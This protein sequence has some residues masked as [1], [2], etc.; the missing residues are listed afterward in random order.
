M[1]LRPIGSADASLLRGIY[2]DAVESQAPALYSDQQ[3]K[4]WAA[5]AWLPG[6]LDRTL[7]EGSGW[8]SGND[9][10]FAIRHPQDRLS[11]LYC[12]GCA[13]RQGHGTALLERIEMEAQAEGVERLCTEASQLSR[14]LLE[15]RGWS[16]VAPE[17]IAIAG[18]P[19]ERY[20]MDKPLRQP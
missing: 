11:L 8:I 2:A 13:A 20:R 9:A 5:L 3:V 4:A 16:V 12:R 1:A 7:K 14:P 19:F 17:I 18:V 10:A 15:R 6:V